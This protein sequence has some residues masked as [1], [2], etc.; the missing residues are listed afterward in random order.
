VGVSVGQIFVFEPGAG[1]R[2][3]VDNFSSDLIYEVYCAIDIKDDC[4]E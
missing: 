3:A 2:H 1:R 4:I